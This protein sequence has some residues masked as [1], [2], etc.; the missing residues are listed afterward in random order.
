MIN[1]TMAKAT[2]N[3]DIET[4]VQTALISTKDKP[5]HS[6]PLIANQ[7]DHVTCWM[8]AQLAGWDGGTK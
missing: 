4:S 1:V 6:R 2:E 7:N 3:L 8:L 5:F